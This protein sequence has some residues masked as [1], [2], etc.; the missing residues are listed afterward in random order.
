MTDAAQPQ[1]PVAFNFANL[2]DMVMRGEIGLA[3]V[4]LGI[5]SIML[6]PLPPWM[7][8][9]LLALSVTSSILVLMT[10]LLIKKP[11]EFTAF[12]SVLLL[13]TLLR[14]SLN[15]ASTRLVLSNGQTGDHAAGQV[16]AAFADF[17]MSGNFVIGVIVF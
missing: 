8:D 6:V 2:R 5:L 15:I 10:A 11:L 14:L 3:L 1:A 13:S 17:V 12:P 7:L 4:V 9:G 16:I